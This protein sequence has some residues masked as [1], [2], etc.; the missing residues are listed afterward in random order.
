MPPADIVVRWPS[1]EEI[2]RAAFAAAKAEGCDAI[3]MLNGAGAPFDGTRVARLYAV[4]ALA[5]QY[6]TAPRADLSRR[7]GCKKAAHDAR[8]YLRQGKWRTFSLDRL[9]AVRA[10]CGWA[11]MTG[12]EAFA[13]PMTLC[14]RHWTEFVAL[15]CDDGMSPAAA[16]LGGSGAENELPPIQDSTL[17]GE[18]FPL[19][20]SPSENGVGAGDCAEKAPANIQSSDGRAEGG[21]CKSE[22]GALRDAPCQLASAK[23]AAKSS[24]ADPLKSNEEKVDSAPGPAHLQAHRTSADPITKTGKAAYGASTASD[25]ISLLIP[26]DISRTQFLPRRSVAEQ[27]SADPARF[28]AKQKSRAITTITQDP[29]MS[30][31]SAKSIISKSTER[32]AIEP[33][34]E[35]GPSDAGISRLGAQNGGFEARKGGLAKEI[36]PRAVAPSDGFSALR[37]A[38]LSGG[39]V[40]FRKADPPPE[41]RGVVL[42]TAE[43]MGDPT[44]EQRARMAATPGQAVRT[45]ARWR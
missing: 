25:D 26:N 44:P 30:G 24:S 2:A 15:R 45:Q 12:E 31:G 16:P 39:T 36:K 18:P 21:L 4:I 11:A 22:L 10:A 3:A 1:A 35:P 23:D 29:S 14:G 34:V 43:L 42:K 17:G 40:S 13:A 8:A 33:V 5:Q 28:A 6:P 9:N 19:C 20:G 38:A 37:A 27:S 41:K 7:L 32:E